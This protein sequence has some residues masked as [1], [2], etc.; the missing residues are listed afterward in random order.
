MYDHPA[1]AEPFLPQTDGLAELVRRAQAAASKLLAQV[2]QISQASRIATTRRANA[3]YSNLLEGQ[4]GAEY[5]VRHETAEAALDS[6]GSAGAQALDSGVLKHIH[7]ELFSS[8]DSALFAPGKLRTQ[9]VK[10]QRHVPPLYEALPAFLKRADQVYL[11]PQNSPDE[12]LIRVAAAHHRMTWI[13]P[14]LD[15]NG[16]A[17]R[18][19]SQLALRPLG[20]RLWSLSA[21]LW[22]RREDYFRFLAEADEHRLGDLD[23]RGNLSEKRLVAWCEF[24]ISVVAEEVHAAASQ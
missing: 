6:I 24:F 8:V 7:S 13:H 17:I 18:L 23:G 15:G 20:S 12:L 4:H 2:P 19:Q 22:R 9:N 16:R 11:R 1:Q 3:L 10:V 14:F 5:L 21:G